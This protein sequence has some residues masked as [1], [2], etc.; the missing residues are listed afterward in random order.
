MER[1]TS[2]DG[3]GDESAMW[4]RLVV[5]QAGLAD[6]DGDGLTDDLKIIEAPIQMITIWMV[7]V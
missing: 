3:D 7:M 1:S 4:M 5:V 2:E 6:S